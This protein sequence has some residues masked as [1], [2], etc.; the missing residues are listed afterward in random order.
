MASVPAGTTIVDLKPVC[1]VKINPDGTLE[2]HKVRIVARGFKQK[3]GVDFDENSI[4][5]PA[6][7]LDS[8][9]MIFAIAVKNKL[10][11]HHFDTKTAFLNTPSKTP[12]YVKVL[13]GMEKD[14]MSYA[15]TNK[16][17]Y[18]LKTSNRDW[19]ELNHKTILE[20]EPR[21]KCS[22]VDPCLYSFHD[23]EANQMVAL[24]VHTDD[25]KCCHN[26]PEW[27]EMF[28]SKYQEH[29]E[30]KDLGEMTQF[31]SMAVVKDGTSLK[32]HQKKQISDYWFSTI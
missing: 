3:P 29:F 20:I 12:A 4:F 13:P 23:K 14:G 22:E 30:I 28:K 6:S 10:S 2:R 26:C 7:Q 32:L 16:C 15:R 17:V 27:Y 9:R 24:L 18:G 19:Y 25:H 8:V 31:L 21:F 11:I 1:T 5:S